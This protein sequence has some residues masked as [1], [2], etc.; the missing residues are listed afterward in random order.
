MVSVGKGPLSALF[1]GAPH[2]NE[3]IGCA[4]IEYLIARLCQDAAFREAL[5]FRWHFIKAIEPDALRL[6]EGWFS[7]PG[8]SQCYYEHYYRPPLNQQAE[9]AF[10]FADSD[11]LSRHPLP[12]NI[13]WQNAIR[14]ARPDFLYSLHNSEAGGVYY[15]A[16]GYPVG[17]AGTLKAI[18]HQSGLPLNTTGETELR[19]SL[20]EPGL[21]HFPDMKALVGM[22]AD[23]YQEN[24]SRPVGNSS[25]CYTAASGT[26]SLFTEVPYWNSPLLDNRQLT[27]FSIRDVEAEL[28]P[29][30][31]QVV[32]L[33]EKALALNTGDAGHIAVNLRQ[34]L[35]MHYEQF[36]APA[37]DDRDADKK[38]SR[39]DKT[40]LSIKGRLERLST[41]GLICRLAG[42]SKLTT[43]CRQILA[44]QSAYLANTEKMT[45]VPVKK[46][47]QLQIHAGLATMIALIKS[48]YVYR[49]R[50]E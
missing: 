19:D 42:D 13:A 45:A 5:P 27:P 22:P 28:A 50:T 18:C 24:G 29:L 48:R 14:Q 10:P 23:D 41:L 32:V 21:F 26:F 8:N 43:E 40:R 46:T 31:A 30:N 34:T 11:W 9:Y 6:N 3:V 7:S 35:Q 1:V 16:S 4:A 33:A 47:C 38:L 12:E 2:P 25:A 20:Y 49:K 36:A 17:L 37:A 39:G 44:E 15:V